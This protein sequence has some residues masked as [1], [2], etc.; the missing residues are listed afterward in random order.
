MTATAP[1]IR[2]RVYSP[3]CYG[4]LCRVLESL[5]RM[6]LVQPPNGGAPF[7]VSVVDCEEVGK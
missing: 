2:V 6:L 5:N 7:W 4:Q 3:R 1:E